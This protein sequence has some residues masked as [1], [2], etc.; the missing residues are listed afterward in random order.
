MIWGTVQSP[1]KEC[2]DRAVGCHAKCERYA[3]FKAESE[4]ERKA[5]YLKKIVLSA[6]PRWQANKTFKGAKKAMKSCVFKD[7]KK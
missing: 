6:G 7:H 3:D 1:C 2:Q 5:F 4:R